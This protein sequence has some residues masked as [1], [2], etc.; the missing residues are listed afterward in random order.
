MKSTK[1]FVITL[2]AGALMIG[3]CA[4]NKS[5]EEKIAAMESR[6]DQKFESVEGQIEDLQQTQRE[7]EQKIAEV[8]K[9]AKDALQRAEQAGILARGHVVFEE[10]FTEDRV[11][12]KSGSAKLTDEAKASLD[13]FGN[14]VKALDRAVWIEIQ[15]HT[16]S[17]GSES[18]NKRLGLDRAEA[19]REYLSMKQGIPLA[20]MSTIS[21]GETSPVQPNNTRDGRMANRRVVLVVLE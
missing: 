20:R 5:V 2:T 4:T 17:T 1:M 19:V 7:Q 10:S 21:Y 11:R 3:G 14:K 8:S 12:F 6:T 16:D 9:E 15:G 13:E 18:Y